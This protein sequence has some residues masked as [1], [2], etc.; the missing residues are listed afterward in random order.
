MQNEYSSLT[1]TSTTVF[2]NLLKDIESRFPAG[3]QL[4]EE[5]ILPYPF[6]KHK[7]TPL[8]LVSITALKIPKKHLCSDPTRLEF[9]FLFM[10]KIFLLP[11]SFTFRAVTPCYFFLKI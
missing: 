8:S 3:Y 11:F 7:K 2:E 9:D 4:M 10:R 5:D 1:S 6:K